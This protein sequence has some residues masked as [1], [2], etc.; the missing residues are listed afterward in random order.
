MLIFD[1]DYPLAYGG[2]ELNRDLTQPLEDVR[3]EENNPA[4][5]PFSCLPE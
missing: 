2:M 5:V 1:G 4:N 3:T